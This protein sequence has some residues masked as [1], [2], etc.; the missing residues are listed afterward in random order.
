MF[1]IRGHNFSFKLKQNQ[2]KNLIFNY[3]LQDE[4]VVIPIYLIIIA[5]SIF[6]HKATNILS[7]IF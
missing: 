5:E 1:L 7:K 6:L 3:F 4:L 2:E